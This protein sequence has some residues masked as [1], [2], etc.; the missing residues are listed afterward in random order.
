MDREWMYV[1][2]RVSQRFFEEL[3]TFLE[4][5][6]K[7]MKPKDIYFGHYICCSYVDCCNEKKTP[8]I[9]EIR[10]HLMVRGFMSRYTCW[11]EHSE[12][13][14]VIHGGQSTIEEEQGNN[15]TVDDNNMTIDNDVDDLDEMLHNVDDEFT[16]KSE[17][18]KFSQMM[19]Y[20]TPPFFGM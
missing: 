7:Y 3:E 17:S 2:N 13:K 18:Q 4:A 5:A 14:E 12:H 6:V 16:S 19:D 9:E 11:M 1:R 20:K 8:D 10:E 15:M